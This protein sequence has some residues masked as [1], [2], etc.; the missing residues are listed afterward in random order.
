[1]N[2]ARS[3]FLFCLVLLCC[4][5]PAASQ[6]A[7]RQRRPA[8]SDFD[9]EILNLLGPRFLDSVPG[10]GV[11]SGYFAT[12]NLRRI[13]GWKSTEGGAGKVA[14]LH[15][16]YW[17]EG[18]GVRNEVI[19]FLGEAMP[20]P[21]PA[22]LA[23]LKRVD[24]LTRLLREN[25]PV[26]ISEVEEFGIERFGLKV[27]RAQPWEIGPPEITNL[28]RAL[29]VTGIAEQRP[30]YLV[31]VRNVSPKCITAIAWYGRENGKTGGGSGLSGACVI[32]AGKDFEIAQR[33]DLLESKEP[34]NLP[35]QLP[36]KREI[37]IA[38]IVFGDGTYEGE[39]DKAAEM[40]AR[41]AGRGIQAGRVLQLLRDAALDKADDQTTALAKL[42]ESVAA[43]GEDSDEAIIAELVTRFA[44]GSA[45][46]RQRRIKTEVRNGMR[47]VKSHIRNEIEQLAFKQSHSPESLDVGAWLKRTNK[48]LESEALTH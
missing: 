15:L 5:I 26:I 39:A 19:V 3:Y 36:S 37:V 13:A 23:K 7:Q 25:E 45:D 28:T 20:S 40:A 29:F 27:V 10:S 46:M 32:A 22:D 33:F 21:R 4:G 2:R 18:D 9:I 41:N 43:L 16:G 31:N 47:S 6:E 17:T 38:V 42:K 14:A 24:V 30:T 11:H 12:N 44:E 8:A 48:M 35:P 1:M 34:E